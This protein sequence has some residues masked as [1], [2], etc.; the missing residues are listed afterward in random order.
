MAKA[1]SGSIPKIFGMTAS[2]VNKKSATDKIDS[3][4]SEIEINLDCTIMTANRDQVEK[5]ATRATEHL[6][7]Y[8][9]PKILELLPE[10]EQ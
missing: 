8:Q 2:I 5:F 1:K 3:V 7:V 10:M 4:F 9:P 6:I